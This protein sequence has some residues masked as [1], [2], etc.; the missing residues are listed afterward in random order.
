MATRAIELICQVAILFAAVMVAT[1][2]IIC[3]ACVGDAPLLASHG[4]GDSDA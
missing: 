1:V 2:A 3:G 4:D